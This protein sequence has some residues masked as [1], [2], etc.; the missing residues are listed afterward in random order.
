MTAMQA[1]IIYGYVSLVDGIVKRM[2][3]KVKTN[4]YVIGTGG[5]ANV[6]YQESETLEEVDEFLT[7]KGL[8]TLLR[9]KQG[10][11]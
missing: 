4:P 7:L 2:K 5:L 10:S 3:E 11:A 8:K 1:G 6:I 9:E